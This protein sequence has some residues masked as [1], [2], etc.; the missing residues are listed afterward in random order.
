MK[1]LLIVITLSL[2]L[3]ACQ[4]EPA[5]KQ[6]K[7][8][9]PQTAAPTTQQLYPSIP[10]AIVQ[11]LF[12]ECDFL[13]VIFNG[14][15]KGV[16]MSLSQDQQNDIRQTL[17]FITT[18]PAQINSNCK[19]TGRMFFLKQGVTLL[20]ADFYLQDGCQYFVF[21]EKG[22]ATYANA[23]SQVGANYLNQMIE[24]AGQVRGQ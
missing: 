16:S 7:T 18:T 11:N 3:F 17:S 1:Y 20:E 8:A 21:F 4:S 22:K 15:F 14:S 23:M 19:T 2:S 24:K 13:D 10:A 12:Q 6:P 9:S 5:A